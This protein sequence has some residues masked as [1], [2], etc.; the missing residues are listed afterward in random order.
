MFIDFDPCH[1][2]SQSKLINK[3]I[4]QA[5][6][7]KKVKTFT[8]LSVFREKFLTVPKINFALFASLHSYD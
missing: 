5:K 7:S 1:L 8:E 4:Q 6:K 2:K 3:I